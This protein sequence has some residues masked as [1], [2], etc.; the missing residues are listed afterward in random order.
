MVVYN[1]FAEQMLSRVTISL[2]GISFFCHI[3]FPCCTK[4]RTPQEQQIITTC[5][6]AHLFDNNPANS[7]LPIFS[8]FL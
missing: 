1:G 3:P 4:L 8:S 7:L 6:R 2:D 5:F